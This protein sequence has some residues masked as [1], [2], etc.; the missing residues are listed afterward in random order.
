[1]G[2]V[3]ITQVE[4]ASTRQFKPARFLSNRHLMTIANNF[5][6]RSFP[7]LGRASVEER[8]V[9]VGESSRVLVYCHWQ[10]DR[11]SHPLILVVHGLEGSAERSYVKG[12]AE[13]AWEL[14][15]NIV[16][17]NVRNCGNTEHLSPTLYDSGLSRDLGSVSK[18]ILEEWHNEWPGLFIVGF[19]MGGNQ[20]LKLAGEMGS[21]SPGWLKGIVAISP[22][23]DLAACAKAIHSG[24]NRVYEKRFLFTL[25][26][27]IRRKARL[28]PG[29]FDL[30]PLHSIHSLRDFDEVFTGP[31]QGYGNADQYYAKASAIRVMDRIRVP[32]LIIQAMDD[33]FVPW[34]CLLNPEIQ[35]NP[36]IQLLLTPNGGHVGF[37]AARNSGPRRRDPYWAEHQAVQFCARIW[38]QKTDAD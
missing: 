35:N 3:K 25:V 13:K 33:P 34:E 6:P 36:Y 30:S 10:P 5:W 9:D 16:R 38:A 20:A 15:F 21:H 37:R 2:S 1:M 28:Y 18:A 17:M 7:V 32:S 12:T 31:Y 11:E 22:P 26:K 24:F 23:V 29:K 4:S 19:S 14:G 8:L 27:L